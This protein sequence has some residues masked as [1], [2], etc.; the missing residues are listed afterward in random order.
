[1]P[2][3]TAVD[4]AVR[5]KRLRRLTGLEVVAVRSGRWRTGSNREELSWAVELADGRLVVLGPDRAVR[6]E[7][8]LSARL[9]EVGGAVIPNHDTARWVWDELRRRHSVS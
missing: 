9:R 2:S 7:R 3:I 4:P 1:V 6:D 8:R 5:F